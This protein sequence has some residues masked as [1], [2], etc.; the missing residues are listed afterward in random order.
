V[1]WSLQ[2]RSRTRRVRMLANRLNDIARWTDEEPYEAEADYRRTLEQCRHYLGD[3]H[4]VT[5]LA[6]LYLGRV[7]RFLGDYTGAVE[8]L[9]TT[10]RCGDRVQHRDVVLLARAVRAT[11]RSSLGAHTE[12]VLELR[13]VVR[14][15]G[16]AWGDE[17][18]ITLSTRAHLATV[19]EESGEIAEAVEHMTDMLAIRC[20]LCGPDHHVTLCSRHALGQA[21]VSAG[22]LDRAEVEFTAAADDAAAGWSCTLSCQYG[23]ARIAAAR[24]QREAAIRGYES[25]I[26][27]WT[28]HL[29]PDTVRTRQAR[30]SLAELTG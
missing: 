13:S 15:A 27:G 8:T 10:I 29:G 14:E 30:E 23:F 22:E 5:L 26:Q 12:A 20:R 17:H 3:G 6:G 7:Q 1:D 11:A 16:S 9:D 19:L 28:D 25:V 21:L 2:L 18:E 24:G 4:E